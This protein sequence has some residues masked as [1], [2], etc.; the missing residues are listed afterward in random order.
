MIHASDLGEVGFKCYMSQKSNF[1]RSLGV[2]GVYG[3][4]PV[5]SEVFV[6]LAMNISV[7]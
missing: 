2:L 5:R 4:L 1:E 3:W 6:L 7:V